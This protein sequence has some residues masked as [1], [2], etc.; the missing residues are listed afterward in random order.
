MSLS[1]LSHRPGLVL[2][3]SERFQGNRRNV[4]EDGTGG[5]EKVDKQ[6]KDGNKKGHRERG[7]DGEMATN[8][9][10]YL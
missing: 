8:L 10:A 1:H 5:K 3:V 6:R 7:S 2:S 9:L 4:G